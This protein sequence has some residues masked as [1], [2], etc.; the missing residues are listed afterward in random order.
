MSTQPIS[1]NP[2]VFALAM[3]NGSMDDAEWIPFLDGLKKSGYEGICLHPRDG[4]RIPY[5]SR[6]FW[7]RYER[8]LSLAQA[9]GFTIWFYD[10]FPF[11]S[12]IHI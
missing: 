4:L 6:K 11:L 7:E 2:R 1:N 10:E 3:L 5:H 9:R 8:I 12:L